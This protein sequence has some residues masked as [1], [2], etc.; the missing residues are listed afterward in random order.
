MKKRRETAFSS[1]FGFIMFWGLFFLATTS[2]SEERIPFAYPA[3]HPESSI[4]VG[5]KTFAERVKAEPP[6]IEFELKKYPFGEIDGIMTRLASGEIGMAVLPLNAL[7]KLE[8]QF[9]V[10]QLP[11]LFEDLG[12]VT[13]FQTS[14]AME[15]PLAE[16]EEKLGIKGL[17]FWH[18]GMDQLWANKPIRI[19]SDAKGLR[20]KFSA[21]K[22]EAL[23]SA[24]E[25]VPL[26]IPFSEAYMA[27][28][29]GV[30]DGTE[31]TW[32]RISSS[33]LYEVPGY[34]LPTNHSYLGFLLVAN[35]SFWNNLPP[36]IQEHLIAISLEV[37]RKVNELTVEGLLG[38]IEEIGQSGETEILIPTSEELE[39]WRRAMEPI[40]KDVEGEIGTDF[41]QA[42]LK[43]GG[44]AG[45]GDPCIPP[46]CRCT[47]RTCDK[48]CCY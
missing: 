48:K 25:A 46:E 28:Q 15:G 43:Y 4:G 11:F 5:V 16:M 13:R 36:D 3:V 7:A 12:A 32:Q 20:F 47:D 42:A 8:V 30:I 26:Q 40:W 10:F 1:L 9:Q 41:M 35:V 31:S 21:P 34:I 24:I 45:G 22:S 19:P 29:R 23:F 38:K 39:Q 44:T 27:L 17:A 14:Q 6:N 2:F 33:R 37:T 18:Y